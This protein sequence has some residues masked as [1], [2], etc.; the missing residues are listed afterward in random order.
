MGAAMQL[1]AVTSYLT[2]NVAAIPLLWILPLAVYLF[3]SFWPFSSLACWPRGLVTRL[4]MVML[5]GL[6]YMLS[7]TDVSLPLRISILFFLIEVFVSCFFC[8]SEAVA[9]R[10]QTRFGVH[11][12]L[13]A[14]CCRWRTGLVRSSALRRRC[15]SLQLRSRFHF[16]CHRAACLA[17][18]W[19]DG[20]S[21]R[22]LWAVASIMMALL[23][24]WLHIAI[25]AKQL[26]QCATST[27]LC[28]CARTM[29]TPAR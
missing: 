11:S 18:T 19:K 3:T 26:R 20:W 2:A 27:A 12:L 16:S 24:S 9:L 5:G 7:K 28:A 8:H 17:V 23:V 25:D 22:L 29:A 21:Q 6:A 10:P 13:S 1:S 15:L 4:L 14:V